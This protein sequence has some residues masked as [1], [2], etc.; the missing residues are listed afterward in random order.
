MKIL[1]Y[2]QNIT[3]RH[4]HEIMI[5][6]GVC[7]HYS[8]GT[9]GRSSPPQ[10]K[11]QTSGN[12]TTCKDGFN[13]HSLKLPNGCVIEVKESGEVYMREDGGQAKKIRNKD[14]LQKL[15]VK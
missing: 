14:S 7:T 5:D 12:E 3:A 10:S 8:G 15:L 4:C 2:N 1:D 6:D 9:R 13:T 11:V